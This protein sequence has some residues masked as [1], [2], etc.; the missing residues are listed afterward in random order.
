MLAKIRFHKNVNDALYYN[1][2]KLKQN[3][4]DALWS[5]NFLKDHHQLTTEEKIDRF[6]QRSTLNDRI[7]GHG[8]H[9][10]LNFGRTEKIDTDKMV[11]LSNYYMKGMGFEDQPYLV[12]RHN[13]AGHTHLHVV[14]SAVSAEGRKVK[15]RPGDFARSR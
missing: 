7:H 9:F 14:A 8:V 4:A 12:Y 15:I 2:E 6:R 11:T 3:K 10:S 13:D 1:E 5:E